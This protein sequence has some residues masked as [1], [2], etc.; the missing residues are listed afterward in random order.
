VVDELQPVDKRIFDFS[1]PL[2]VRI[3]AINKYYETN[4]SDILEIV[5]K[6]NAIYC[7]SPI[8][9][10]RKSIHEIS[11]YCQGLPIEIRIEC[12]LTLIGIE[13]SFVM[14][15]K[16]LESLVRDIENGPRPAAI[17]SPCRLEYILKIINS[18]LYPQYIDT[19]YAFVNDKSMPVEYRYKSILMLENYSI[20]CCI[21][22]I[23]NTENS[24]T[25]RILACQNI[26][27]T[28][29]D[30]KFI[31][32]SEDNL[33]EFMSNDTLPHN[34]RA[35]AADVILHY[36]RDELIQKSLEILKELGGDNIKSL[37]DNKE[38]VHTSSIETSVL[39]IILFLD[40]L[41]IAQVPSFETVSFNLKE[42]TKKLHRQFSYKITT[43]T[44]K[45]RGRYVT[46]SFKTDT[47]EYVEELSEQEKQVESALLRIDLDRTIF[48]TTNHT[49]KS[50]LCRIYA[51]IQQQEYDKDELE[52]RL[53]EELIDMSGTCSSGYI[54]RLV[55]TLSGFSEN[56][57]LAISWEDQ[58]MANLTG[59]LNAKMRTDEN[60]EEILE[61]M[62]NT[63]IS[64]R[65]AFLKFY[66]D[67]ISTISEEM[68][69]E[70]LDYMTEADWDIYFKKAILNYTQ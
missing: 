13:S 34:V 53:I 37:Y 35:D 63:K 42:R 17:P 11:M 59:R 14:G 3:E 51:Y 45:E 66:R 64:D 67:N 10:I 23:E 20:D 8:G 6:L 22:F 46:K 19:L 41:N 54:S 9:L 25:Y 43:R 55:N 28:S 33:V 60:V 26:L 32:F 48:K 5:C 61:Q 24:V 2:N 68:R 50:V 16:C 47:Q 38:N 65:S 57:N 18:G 52:V 69:T 30:E 4:S 44:V 27:C 49:L 36:G 7:M 31:D 15:M 40:T 21:K 62:T 56:L 70:F 39:Q 29:E 58:I 12:A 1:L